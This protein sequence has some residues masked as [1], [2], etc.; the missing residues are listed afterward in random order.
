MKAVIYKW[1]IETTDIQD[2]TVPKGTKILTVQTQKHTPCIWGLVPQDSTEGE[3][4]TLRVIGTGHP[5]E[6]ADELEYI[7]T[8][9]IH[10]GQLVFHVFKVKEG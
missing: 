10:D 7:G 8:Y 1:Q 6:N 3:D 5:I 2:V 4:I 9:Q